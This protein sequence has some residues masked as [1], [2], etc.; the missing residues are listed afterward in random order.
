MGRA[1]PAC[2]ARL[3]KGASTG[4]SRSPARGGQIPVVVAPVRTGSV[5][6]R[7]ESVGTVRPRDAVTITT[8]VA[9]IV[10]AVRFTKG[11]N[12]PTQLARARALPAGQAVAQ[13]RVDALETLTRGAD[14][15]AWCC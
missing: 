11:Q 1:Q 10:T 8:R 12:V 7:V 3:G 9:G 5:T 14:R 13:A 4:T 6:G 2:L 15:S